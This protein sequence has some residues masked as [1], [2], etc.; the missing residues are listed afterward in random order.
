MH[1]IKIDTENWNRK[2]TFNRFIKDNPCSYSMTVN[3]D[4]TNFLSQVR[5][6][7][8][9][10][11]PTFLYLLSRTVNMHSEFRMGFDEEK[12]LGYYSCSNPLYTIFHSEPET[13]TTV[14]S[15]Y[16]EDYNTFILNYNT[17]MA[18]Y[19][20]DE[21]IS[22]PLALP[23][24]FNVSSIP[25]TSFTGFNLNLQNG[26][27]YL[28]PIFTIGKYYEDNEKTL[29]PLAIQVNHAVCDGYHLARFVNDLQDDLYLIDSRSIL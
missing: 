4:I 28:S 26:Y 21:K 9:K 27:D 16:D 7:R 15:E 5:A 14:W 13:F 29:L 17:D 24:Y 11:F 6:K 1:F 2:E 20:L 3:L 18:Q 23:N 8:I 10:F 12:N 22:K 19:R 25:W